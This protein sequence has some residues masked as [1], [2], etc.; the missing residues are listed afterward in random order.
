MELLLLLTALL[1]ALTG[2]A[3]QSRGGEAMTHQ[4]AAGVVVAA[5]RLVAA[6]VRAPVRVLPVADTPVDSRRIAS[7]LRLFSLTSATPLYATR[8]RE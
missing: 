3:V 8:L 6:Q 2:A 7:P 4:V 1:S 5:P